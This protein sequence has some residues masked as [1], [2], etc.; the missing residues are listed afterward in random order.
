MRTCKTPYEKNNIYQNCEW[1][2]ILNEWPKVTTA[3]YQ[4]LLNKSLNCTNNSISRI[5]QA[6]NKCQLSSLKF[7]TLLVANISLA[8]FRPG[9][10]KLF[11]HI[12]HVTRILE[13]VV[14]L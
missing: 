10:Q 9:N 11:V 12:I 2:K 3:L 4:F 8:M 13:K 5:W 6:C 14:F 7:H 1:L